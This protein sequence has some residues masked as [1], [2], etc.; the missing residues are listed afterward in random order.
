MNESHVKEA[1]FYYKKEENIVLCELC[2]NY[3]LILPGK[4]GRCNVRENKEGTLYSLSYGNLISFTQDPIEKKPFYHIIPGTQS[5]SIA[6]F[7]CNLHCSFCQNWQIS[8]KGESKDETQFVSPADVIKK[9]KQTKSKSISYTYT[10]PTIFYEYVLDVARLAKKAG[11][12]NLLVT[13]GYINPKPL[14]KIYKYIDGANID[15]KFFN[16]DSYKKYCG[17]DLEPVLETIRLLKKRGV[18]IEITHLLIPGLNDDLQELKQ[19]CNWIV[20]QV[21]DDTPIHF[22]R[23]FPRYKLTD[24]APTDPKKLEEAYH[25]AKNAG[26]KHVYIG[27]I[28]S[29]KYDTTFCKNCDCVLIRRNLFNITSNNVFMGKCKACGTHADGIW[30]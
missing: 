2:P 3:C 24:I 8:Q 19:M 21:G 25:I 11:I 28:P 4:L 27:N 9:A 13:N 7:G 17:G 16:P 29:D 22:S 10:E 14:K 20:R 15:L 30:Y 1:Q 12:K 5:L 23:F 6:T 26:L 18:W